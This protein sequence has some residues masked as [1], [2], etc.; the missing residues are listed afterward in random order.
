MESSK[1]TTFHGG[2]NRKD[3]IA[4]K[5]FVY[6]CDED[7]YK[8]I[9]HKYNGLR[10]HDMCIF[11]NNCK[12]S[13]PPY[14]NNYTLRVQKEV[15]NLKHSYNNNNNVFHW[16]FLIMELRKCLPESSVYIHFNYI[17]NKRQDKMPMQTK[18]SIVCAYIC[19]RSRPSLSIAERATGEHI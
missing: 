7:D 19:D 10:F 4:P 2:L 12:S 3:R 6:I 9:L 1:S 14:K 13:H 15:N 8:N 18:K 11:R 16:L 17:I 5:D